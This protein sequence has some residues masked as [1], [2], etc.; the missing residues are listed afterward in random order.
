[1][2][3][4][5][6]ALFHRTNESAPGRETAGGPFVLIVSFNSTPPLKAESNETNIQWQDYLCRRDLSPSG[7][8]RE[9][10]KSTNTPIGA[11]SMDSDKSFAVV[12]NATFFRQSIRGCSSKRV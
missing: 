5:K 2:K 6:G 4:G 1:M 8:L 3:S 7:R 9:S 10:S 11:I 12:I